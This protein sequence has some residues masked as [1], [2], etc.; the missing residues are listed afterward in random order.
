MANII[1]DANALNGSK[2]SNPVQVNER[3]FHVSLKKDGSAFKNQSPNIGDFME[4]VSESSISWVDCFL[5]DFEKETLATALVMGFSEPLVKSLLTNMR[6][7]YE[8]F[9]N[10][11]GVIMPAILAKGFDVKLNPLMV[12]IKDNLILTMHTT[13]VKRFFRLR[14]Y[15]VTLMKK[16]PSRMPKSDIITSILL[17]IIDENNNRNFEHLLEIEEQGDKLSEQLA[18][19]N[20]P[21]EKLGAQIHEMK[22]AL[23]VYL[24][25]LWASVDAL[26]SLRYGDADLLTDNVKLL[27]KISALIYEVNSHIQLAEHLSEVLASGLEV[28]QSIYNNQLQIFNNRVALLGGYLAIIGTALLVPNTIATALS[29]PV[30]G[31]GP[32]DAPW[33]MQV[34]VVS[35]IVSAIVAWVVVKKLGLLPKQPD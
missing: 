21:R 15:A 34:M 17:R 29:S 3:F 26:N 12:L 11:M 10:E 2:A 5:D 4:H 13:E 16:F 20:T 33:F 28:V 19:S 31:L 8:D 7:N 27:E 35:T 32:E 9:G 22:H 30:F 6:S 23:M 18:D 1:E 24:S 14:R 25:G